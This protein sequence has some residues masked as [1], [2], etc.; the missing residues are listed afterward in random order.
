[1]SSADTTRRIGTLASLAAIGA[2]LVLGASYLTFGVV[3]VDW[4][5]E[6]RTATMLVP[7]SGGLLPRSKVLL[8]GIEVGSVGA[9]RHTGAGIEV[10]FDYDAAYQLPA[11]STVRIE[12]LSGLG[13]PYIEFRPNHPGGPYL[14]DGA[15]VDA[16]R[17]IAPVSIPE[18]ARSATALLQQLDPKALSRIVATFSTGLEGTDALI[19]QLSRSTDLLAATLLS[20]TDLIRQML[21]DMQARAERMAWGGGELTG[22]AAAWADFGPRVTEVADAIARVIRIGDTPG[23]Y[24]LDTPETIGLVPL[25]DE[26][27]VKVHK[28][29]PELRTLLP[30]LEPLF[31]LLPGPISRIDLG[32]LISQ[33]LHATSPDGLRLQIGIR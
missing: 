24:L 12:A 33:A 26:L 10:V 18:V 29:G 17:I 9:V 16:A 2:I 14:A 5:A 1:M 19:P 30:V 31:A 13:E 8:S 4:F 28:L 21:V 27:A 23:D 3:K 32:S 7:D 22:A 25:L 20:R 15:R 6:R 11:D